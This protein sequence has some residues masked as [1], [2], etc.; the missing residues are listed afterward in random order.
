MVFRPVD[1]YNEIAYHFAQVIYVH[2]YNSSLRVFN[3]LPC[4]CWAK[5]YAV[6]KILIEVAF[7]LPL[8]KQHDSSSM[9]SQV[10]SSS[11][12]TPL[13]GYQ[14]SASNQVFQITF[15]FLLICVVNF[16]CIFR[17]HISYV[18]NN[19]IFIFHV[20]VSRIQHGWDQR[21]R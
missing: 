21:C 16:I 8:Q 5:Q 15:F 18:V 6:H 12:N 2:S 7:P 1:D 10:P 17:H 3:K 20:S 9:P 4:I 13:K 19:F 14:A 11:F